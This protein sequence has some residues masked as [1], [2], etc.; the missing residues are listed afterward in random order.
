MIVAPRLAG[1]LLTCV[2]EIR[3]RQLVVVHDG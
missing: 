1:A 3:G 2:G